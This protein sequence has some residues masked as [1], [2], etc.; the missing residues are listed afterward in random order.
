MDYAVIGLGFGDEGKGLMVSTL[1]NRNATKK[2]IVIR[3]NGTCQAGH[4]VQLPD[5]RKHVFSHFGSGTLQGVPTMWTEYCPISPGP[6]LKERE[7]LVSLGVQ[8]VLYVDP[9]CPVITPWDWWINQHDTNTLAHGTCGVGFG[10]CIKRHEETPYKLFAEDLLYPWVLKTKLQSI[11][12]FYIPVFTSVTQADF[13]QAM[14]DKFL[15]DC[16]AFSLLVTMKPTSNVLFRFHVRIFEGAQGILLDQTHG[17]FPNVT[18]SNT[19]SKNIHSFNPKVY[20]MTRSYLTRH[21]NGPMPNQGQSIHTPNPDETN[22]N[23]KFQGQFKTAPLNLELLRYA[24]RI[25]KQYSYGNHNLVV[26]CMDQIADSKILLAG[27][28]SQY[29]VEPAG[30]RNRLGH[31]DSINLSYGPTYETMQ[32]Y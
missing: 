12:K 17:F 27:Y 6:M 23:N 16:E 15:E 29:L 25:D 19:T 10:A 9:K 14:L 28:D 8:P 7:H 21:G 20:Y 3:F 5:G 24:L 26:T 1:C 32:C 18:R 11:L 13:H 30:L 22:I 4:T 2:C 31:F